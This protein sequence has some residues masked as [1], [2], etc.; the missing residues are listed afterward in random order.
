VKRASSPARIYRIL[1]GQLDDDRPDA[2]LVM[3]L[4]RVEPS[5]ALAR[6]WLKS[7][8][9]F[10]TQL[11]ARGIGSSEFVIVQEKEH[12]SLQPV[13]VLVSESLDE[14]RLRKGLDETGST[15]PRGTIA[16]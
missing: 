1:E 16:G 8:D 15:P 12:Y 13:T 7:R 6:S 14:R 3:E 5:L 4:V 2:R 11:K 9:C 10:E